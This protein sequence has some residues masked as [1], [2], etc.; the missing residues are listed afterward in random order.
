MNFNKGD[1]IIYKDEFYGTIIEFND[2]LEMYVVKFDD[3]SIG[4]AYE[5]DLE[6]GME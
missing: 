5:I 3:G 6:E 1:T 4:L 2:D